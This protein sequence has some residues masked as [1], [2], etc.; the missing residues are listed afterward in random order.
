MLRLHAIL[1]AGITGRKVKRHP[2]KVTIKLESDQYGVP[3][4]FHI[5]VGLGVV[6]S[7]W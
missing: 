4:A 3:F 5:L 6:H 7:A 1:T 2:C